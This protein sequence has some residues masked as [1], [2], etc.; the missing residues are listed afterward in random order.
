MKE[1]AKRKESQKLL[2]LHTFTLDQGRGG[3]NPNKQSNFLAPLRK[4]SHVN[5]SKLVKK[6]ASLRPPILHWPRRR[7]S[8]HIIA[9]SDSALASASASTA[10]FAILNV[11]K[12]RCALTRMC[13][14]DSAHC[15]PSHAQATASTSTSSTSRSPIHASARFNASASASAIT[16][17][18]APALFPKHWE[19]EADTTR[20]GH[21]PQ[22]FFA[23][24]Q[25]LGLK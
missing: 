1:R 2:L 21:C 5:A 15:L 22:K 17:S 23:S 16:A 12:G 6:T 25:E 9:P 3:S 10:S 20:A 18:L 8:Q 14:L 11:A 13:K 19:K 24:F 7:Q 4:L